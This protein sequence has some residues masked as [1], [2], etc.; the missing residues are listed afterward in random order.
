MKINVKLTISFLILTV[1]PLCIVGGVNY[2]LTRDALTKVALENLNNVAE[3]KEAQILEFFASKKS[4]AEN[5]ASDGFIRDRLEDIISTNNEVEKNTAVSELTN[6]LNVNKKPLDK[7]LLDVHILNLEGTIISATMEEEIGNNESAVH[8]FTKALSETYIQDAQSYEGHRET[9]FIAVG[10]PIRSRSSNKIIGVLMNSYSL[11]NMEDFITG[12]RAKKLGAP[13]TIENVLSR[14]IFMV[15]QEGAMIIPSKKMQKYAYL[16]H[17]IKEYE[18]VS[19][20]INET[21]EINKEWKD[22]FDNYVFGASMCPQIEKD[23]KWTLIVEQNKVE[24]LAPITNLRNATLVIGSFVLFLS[25]VL[26][27]IV[28]NSLARPIKKL[29]SVAVDISQGNLNTQISDVNSKDEIGDLARAFNRIVT[30]LK[31]A[32]KKDRPDQ[33]WPKLDE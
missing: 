11:K 20:C 32:M 13:T 22:N 29:T 24:V 14:D 9:V 5:F 33:E 7:D 3:G 26:A 19:K 12:A 28:A 31:L 27:Y 21:E 17:N 2:W 15:N 6:H 23:W 4:Q 16:E 18:P 25:V 10:T 30:S 8:Y 1:I